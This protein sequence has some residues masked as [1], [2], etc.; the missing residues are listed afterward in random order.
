MHLKKNVLRIVLYFTFDLSSIKS[1]SIIFQT[2]I[3]L[4]F[5]VYEKKRRNS[6]KPH[7]LRLCKRAVINF[8][9]TLCYDLTGGCLSK[10]NSDY[11]SNRS[12]LFT[13]INIVIN[14]SLKGHKMFIDTW[15]FHYFIVPESTLMPQYNDIMSFTKRFYFTRFASL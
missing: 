8:A 5:R 4:I 12:V 11:S 13:I 7:S 2:I 1:L 15:T 9:W 3:I 14:N 10:N 6:L